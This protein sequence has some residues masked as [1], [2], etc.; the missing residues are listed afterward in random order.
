M[1]NFYIKKL[2][3]LKNKELFYANLTNASLIG[4]FF[5]LWLAVFFEDDMENIFAY[6]LILTF[7]IVHGANDLKLIQGIGIFKKINFLKILSYYIAF[8]LLSSAFFYFIPAIALGL[9]V[10]FSG[11]HFG[12]Q[13]WMSKTKGNR[14]T[15]SIFYLSYGLFVLFLLFFLHEALVHTVILAITNIVLPLNFYLVGIFF[16]GIALMITYAILNYKNFNFIFIIKELFLLFVFFIVFSTASLLWSFAIYFILW[17]SLPSL[18]DQIIFLYGSCTKSNAVAYF[19]SS[20][21]YWIVAVIGLFISLF[22]FKDNFEESL[23][24]FFS[25]LAAITFPHVLVINRLNKT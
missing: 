18:V 6:F 14:A 8:I 5:S 19:K 23:A 21:A 4:T 1:F 3:I 16:S 7:G 24:L 13:H 22:F 10:L 2:N 15:C 17:H 20:F 11:Y 9:F 12:E 25:L